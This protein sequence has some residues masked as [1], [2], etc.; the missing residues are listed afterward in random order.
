MIIALQI[1]TCL[2]GGAGALYLFGASVGSF[3]RGTLIG[4]S[5]NALAFFALIFTGRTSVYGTAHS[6]K[7][8][9]GYPAIVLGLCVV[10]LLFLKALATQGILVKK[11]EPWNWRG[12]FPTVIGAIAGLLAGL[13]FFIPKWLQ[14][15]VGE[16]PQDPNFIFILTAAGDTSTDA[17][18]LALLNEIVAP[19]IFLALLGAS[20]GFI[21]SDLRIKLP[22]ARTWRITHLRGAALV[23][24]FAL[25][26]G[27]FGYAYARLPIKEAA[28]LFFTTSSYLEENYV[29]PTSDNVKLPAKKRNLVHIYM[30]SV[31]N[32]YYSKDLGGYMEQNLMPELAALTETGISWSDTDK[33]GG[34]DQL[35]ATGHSVAGMISMQAGVPMLAAGAPDIEIGYSYPDFTSI[36]DILKAAGYNTA[37]MQASTASWG[38]LDR[39]YQRH[40]GFDIHDRAR[41]VA[42]GKI[43]HDYFVWWG[44]EDD[45]LYEYTKEELTKLGGQDKPFYM[46]VENGDTHFP[47]GYVSENMKE[48]PF[49][50]QYANVIHYSQAETVKLI[51]WIQEQ[52]WGDDTTIVVTGDHR[53]MDKEFFKGWDPS[54]HRTIVNLILNP[55]PGTDF[56]DSVTKNRKFS[57][58]DLFPTI[59]TAIGAEV[60]GDRLGLG[61]N[62]FSGKQTLV[63]RDGSQL[64]NEEFAKRSPFYDSHRETRAGQP[65]RW[66][67]DKF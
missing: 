15:S 38:G 42:D 63:E 28:Q 3:I 57:T 44:V 49:D 19:A 31:E 32:S 54:Y 12:L 62:M 25:L 1:L 39:Y 48:T 8:Y 66:Q 27:S 51:K 43:E 46:I 20:I 37:F 5:M 21:R 29:A 47:D 23:S 33:F 50:S 22:S 45:K 34:P 26:A 56:P 60:E 7:F 53:S 59:L 9:V 52:P 14:N 40:G 10:I 36:G 30:E 35:Y 58:F 55:V 65:A 64:M 17:Q 24:I 4:V 18:D 67:D 41:F 16:I 13:F 11:S 2:L 6:P 61:M